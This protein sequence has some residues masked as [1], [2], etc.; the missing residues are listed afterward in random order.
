MRTT[1]KKIWAFLCAVLISVCGIFCISC[2][3]ENGY[4]SAVYFDAEISVATFGKALP[5]SVKNEITGILDELSHEFS[6]SGDGF[7]ATFNSAEVGVAVSVPSVA[8][9]VLGKIKVAHGISSAFN[10][11]VLPFLRLWHFT[12]DTKIDNGGFI[13][14]TDEEIESVKTENAFDPAAFTFNP[15]KTEVVKSAN[16]SFDVGGIIKG[17]AVDKITDL[18]KNK[19]YDSG[20]VNFGGSS[21]S[22]LT[23]D[24]LSVTHPDDVGKNILRIEK[25]ENVSVSTSG[26]YRTYY[27]HE[28]IRY[29]HV[30]DPESGRPVGSGTTS[31]VAI[32]QSGWLTDAMSTALML[33]N[34]NDAIDL[35]KTLTENREYGVNSVF[36]II[37]DGEEKIVLTNKKQGE[38]TLLDRSY[39]VV[40]V[41]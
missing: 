1:V 21:I 38:F 3:E 7:L 18:L 29:S 35:I 25:P 40:T 17:V 2:K 11:A 6:L 12:P 4:Y 9:D 27:E 36:V 14:P 8:A 30:I 31:A 37:N 15:N 26:N 39:S 10:P 41:D 13:P 24:S 23:A 20:Y 33:L 34:R 28:G 19:G 32:G 22:I 16:I 5:L